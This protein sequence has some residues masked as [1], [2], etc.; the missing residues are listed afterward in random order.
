MLKEILERS[1]EKMNTVYGTIT[2]KI[3][4]KNKEILSVSPEIEECR[5]I[6]EKNKIS[7]EKV[8]RSAL[9]AWEN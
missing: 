3:G 2:M 4:R 9:S 7:V 6:A 1:F 8:Y 5:A